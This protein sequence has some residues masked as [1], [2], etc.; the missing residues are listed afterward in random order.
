MQKKAFILVN[1]GS[2]SNLSSKAVKDFLAE[3]L[4]DPRVIDLPKPI[5]YL[6][7]K[8]IILPFRVKPLLKK[9]AAIWTEKGAPLRVYSK[10]LCDKIN[11]ALNPNTNITNATSVYYAMR[12]GEPS[13]ASVLSECKKKEIK[14]IYFIPLYPQFS[15][16]TTASIFDAVATFYHKQYSIPELHFIQAYAENPH[17]IEALAKTIR[18][19]VD[20][21]KNHLLISFHGLPCRYIEKGDPY[22]AQCQATTS[23]LIK[24]LNLTEENYTLAYQ[25]RF[26]PS[27][28]LQPSTLD[29][30]QT[31]CKKGIKNIAVIC[32]GFSCDCLE[33]LEEINIALKESFLLAGGENF[34]YIPALNDSQEQVNLFLSLITK[35]DY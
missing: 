22:Q 15:A 16:S 34:T 4:S 30:T 2:P 31:L 26:G 27:K 8:G 32:P 5:R 21:T 17:Y 24:Y 19:T 33:T 18:T 6:L 13:I 10:G 3:F 23:A 9:Y 12:Y 35:H 14:K 25:S 20:L 28:W 29:I 7:L 11:Q 1:L